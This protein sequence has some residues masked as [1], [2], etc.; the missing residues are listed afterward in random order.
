MPPADFPPSLW[1]SRETVGSWQ[2]VCL[3]E[4]SRGS[5]QVNVTL[6]VTAGIRADV[7]G[8]AHPT[9]WRYR[10]K[11]FQMWTCRHWLGVGS[12]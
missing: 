4:E 11:A 12:E 7:T 5:R 3:A 9:G 6:K 1:S 8:L 10:I 2:T